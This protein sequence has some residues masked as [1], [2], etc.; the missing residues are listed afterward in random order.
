MVCKSVVDVAEAFDDAG[1]QVLVRN[2]NNQPRI[3]LEEAQHSMLHREEVGSASSFD[4]F[5][6]KAARERAESCS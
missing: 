1:T 6:F 4:E 2:A 3:R 5:C